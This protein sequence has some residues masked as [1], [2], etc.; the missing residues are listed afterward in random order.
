[1]PVESYPLENVEA[2]YGRA[3][4]IQA[5]FDNCFQFSD[6]LACSPLVDAPELPV[7][8][9]LRLFPNPASQS[10]TIDCQTNS[11]WRVRLMD[12]TGRTVYNQYVVGPATRIDVPVTTLSPGIYVAEMELTNGMTRQAKISI[13]R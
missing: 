6:V 10:F 8:P 12:M 11:L 7:A 13:V 3:D 9:Q 5:F 4:A 2:M 1:M